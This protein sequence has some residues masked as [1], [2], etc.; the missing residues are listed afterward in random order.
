MCPCGAY[1]PFLRDG[2]FNAALSSRSVSSLIPGSPLHLTALSRFDTTKP[3]IP[4]RAGLQHAHFADEEYSLIRITHICARFPLAFSA[5][6]IPIA[7]ACPPP[8]A[9][10]IPIRVRD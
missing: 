10:A 4:Y 8:F 1:R 6:L 9:D 2:H 3:V 7:R 5:L